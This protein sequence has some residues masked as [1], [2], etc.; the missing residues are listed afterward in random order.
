ML[1]TLAAAA[2]EPDV[3][4]KLKKGYKSGNKTFKVHIDGYNLLPFLEGEAKENP[5]KGFLYW[6]DDGDLMALRV[7]HW[8]ATFM[9]QR[10]RSRRMVRAPGVDARAASLQPE[11]SC[12]PRPSSENS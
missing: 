8:K 3:I 5:R 6:S 7:G 12:R 10:A 9:E 4:E 1:P 2:G 11:A